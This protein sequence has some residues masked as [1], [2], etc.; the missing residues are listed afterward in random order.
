MLAPGRLGS[1]VLLPVL[2]GHVGTVTRWD[3]VFQ[4]E[5]SYASGR[6]TH[7]ISIVPRANLTV[8]CSATNRLGDDSRSI[9]V[10]SSEFWRHL[11]LTSAGVNQ[12][13]DVR[14]GQTWTVTTGG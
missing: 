3:L 14:C 11:P 8:T 1:C 12:E 2:C 13:V 7:S 10:S 4:E 9:N 6:A 5:S